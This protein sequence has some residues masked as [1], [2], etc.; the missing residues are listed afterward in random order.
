MTYQAPGWPQPA[1]GGYGYDGAQPK[2][3][4]APAYASAVVFAM[5]SVLTLVVALISWNGRTSNYKALVAVPGMAFS[6]DITGNVD[7]AI[8]ASMIIMGVVAL[9]TLLLAV[10]LEFAR[11]LVGIV[12]GIVVLYFAYALVKLLIDEAPGAFVTPVLLS[13][14]L[15][16]VADVLVFLPVT[17]RAM[18]RPSAQW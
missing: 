11:V 2:P 18:R 12:G 17:K 5:C 15:W 16:L 9:L 4:T 14:L 7:F 3:S 1:Y 13:F 8:T 6:K 10:R